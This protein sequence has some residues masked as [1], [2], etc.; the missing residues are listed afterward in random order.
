MIKLAF[1]KYGGLASGGTEIHLQTLAANLPKNLFS[2]DYYYCDS[3][4]YIGSDWIHPDTDPFREKYLRNNNINLIKF[5]VEAKDIT[6]KHH[7]WVN[8]NF[9]DLFNEDNYDVIISA[10]AGHPEYPFTEIIKKPLIFFVTLNAGVD[11]QKNIY[12][13][14]L[15]SNWQAR[16]WLKM[17]GD[18]SRYVVLPLLREIEIKNIHNNKN[19]EIFSYGFHQ[20]DNDQIFSEVPLKAYR[21]VMSEKTIFKILGGSKLYSKQAKEL[22]LVN[23]EQFEHTGDEKKIHEFLSS[24]DVFAHGRNDGETFGLVFTEAMIYGLPLLSHK[25][26]NNAQVEVVG[27]AGKVFHRKNI[28]GYAYEMNKLK[29]NRKYYNKISKISSNRYFENYSF[30]KNIES[31]IRLIEDAAKQFL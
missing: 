31:N 15:I 10:R 27:D 9:W 23:F 28:L 25:S 17:G 2:I 16:Q 3:T 18:K 20:R 30:E 14:V 8:T 5:N 6:Q 7:P 19:K 29:N 12:K 22:N 24:L 4:K 26:H 21:R 13:N 1:I 11:N